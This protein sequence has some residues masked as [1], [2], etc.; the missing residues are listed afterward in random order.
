MV[1]LHGLPSYAYLVSVGML[2]LTP[3]PTPMHI[4][5]EFDAGLGV[6]QVLESPRGERGSKQRRGKIQ[7]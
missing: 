1:S 3:M 6:C 2:V 5:A 4:L 7:S